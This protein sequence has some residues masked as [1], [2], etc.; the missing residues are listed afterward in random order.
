MGQDL[1]NPPDVSGWKGGS[2]WINSTTLFE[3]FS[4]GLRLATARDPNRPYF[5]DVAGQI[6][7]WG[8]TSPDGLVDSYLGLLVDGDVAPEARQAL[9]DYLD[10]SGPLDL[11]DADAIDLKARGL[12]HLAMAVP[13]FQLA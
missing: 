5:A 8:I 3:R 13:S 6:Q 7:S 12:L 11:S 1:L 9:I 4:W 2:A 10:T